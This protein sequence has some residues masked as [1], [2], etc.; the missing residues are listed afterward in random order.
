M[1]ILLSAFGG[2]LLTRLARKTDDRQV[3]Y[4]VQDVITKALAQGR[5]G[6]IVN[7]AAGAADAHWNSADRGQWA[8]EIKCT[9]SGSAALTERDLEAP[10]SVA[11]GRI[12]MV[13]RRFPVRIAVLPA[14]LIGPGDCRLAA[15][16]H[17]GLKEEE[18][19]LAAGMERVLRAADMELLSA[20]NPR[21]FIQGLILGPSGSVG[22]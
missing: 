8:W 12:V 18:R 17:V 9:A 2:E 4:V 10:K 5:P 16:E 22:E 14:D 13:D 15:W 19:D 11:N 1:S 7:N 6:L 21:E 20:E 3:G